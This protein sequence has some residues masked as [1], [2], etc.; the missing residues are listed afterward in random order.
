MNAAREVTATFTLRGHILTVTKSGDG[1]GTVTSSPSGIDCGTIC[2]ALFPID[3]DGHAYRD[4]LG[5]VQV[6]R[7]HRVHAGDRAPTLRSPTLPSARSGWT[8]RET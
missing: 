7:V 6:H 5:R 1:T 2:S 4:A 3:Y 8:L